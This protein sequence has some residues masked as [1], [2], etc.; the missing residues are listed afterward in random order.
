MI[1]MN[2]KVQLLSMAYFLK[3]GMD[4]GYDYLQLSEDLRDSLA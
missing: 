3:Q 1:L 2:T 4:L